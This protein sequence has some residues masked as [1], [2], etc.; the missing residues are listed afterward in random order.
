MIERIKKFAAY[1]NAIPVA[2][3]VLVGGSAVTLAASPDAREAA[4]GNLIGEEAR[5]TSVDNAAILAAKLDNHDFKLKITNIIEDETEYSVTYVFTTYIVQDA[6]WQKAQVERVLKVS[7]DALA[8]RDLGDY[9]AEELKEVVDFERGQ[10]K[11][12]QV[13]E[14]AQ[15][16]T[17]KI[18]TITYS[19]LIG[20]FLD[21]K[22]REFPGYE[23]VVKD[24]LPE[25]DNASSTLAFAGKQ[26]GTP[27]I[28]EE[29]IGEIVRKI[30]EQTPQAQPSQPLQPVNSAPVQGPLIGDNTGTGSGSSSGSGGSGGKKL[31]IGDSPPGTA[32]STPSN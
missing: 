7:K 32:T 3:S 13:L 20:R 19:G 5:I 2:I 9:C 17:K 14:L 31:P 27:E 23:K 6:V 12:T 22:R 15:G 10:L 16:A 11:E 1:H 18:E 4:M 25:L 28:T 8:G 26:G 30:L 29:R 21:D 24:A